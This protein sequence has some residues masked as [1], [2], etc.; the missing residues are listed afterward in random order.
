MGK[1]YGLFGTVTGKIG[2]VVMSSNAGKTIVRQYQPNVKNPSTVAQSEQRAKLKLMSQVSAAL[3]PVIAINR[4]GLQSSRNLFIKRNFGYTMSES[5]VA[6]VSYENLQLTSGSAGLPSIS[7]TRSATEGIKI[8]LSEAADSAISIVVYVLYK[9][10]D[11]SILQYVDSVV[12]ETAGDDGK[13]PGVLPYTAGDA[14]LYAYGMK[15]LSATAAAKY[16]NYS[17]TNAED[18]AQLV[19]SRNLTTSDYQF[20]MTRG[21]TLFSG[22]DQSTVVPT[23]SARVFVTA[24]GNGTVEGAGVF[25]IG[26]NVTVKATPGTNA[27]FVNWTVNGSSTS[28]STS[29]EYTFV[30]KAQTDLVANFSSN[31]GDVGED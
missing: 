30:L 21:T 29:A 11:E 17:V 5:G 12:V 4:N 7:A 14:I 19:Y 20:T 15:A 2:N 24:N 23:G 27:T 1:A 8:Q 22:E 10:T 3:A 25:E 26:K 13:F 28:V 18:V 16:Q 6:S 9:K 31:S